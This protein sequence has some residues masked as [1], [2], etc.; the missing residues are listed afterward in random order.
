MSMSAIFARDAIALN[1][2]F[3]DAVLWQSRS[4]SDMSRVLLVEIMCNLRS[5]LQNVEKERDAL[6]EERNCSLK[7]EL[8]RLVQ[9]LKLPT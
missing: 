5:R 1:N 2:Y 7:Y 4:S 3:L 9:R 8:L 6:E